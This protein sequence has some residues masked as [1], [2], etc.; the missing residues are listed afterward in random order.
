[1]FLEWAHFIDANFRYANEVD[2]DFVRKSIR[3]IGRCAIKIADASDKCVQVLLELIKGG[4][5]YVVQESIVVVKDI[6][7]KYPQKYE[8][9]IPALCENLE[10]LDNADAKAALVWIIGEYSAKIDNAADLL[11][12]FFESFEDDHSKVRLYSRDLLYA[13]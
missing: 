10:A 7:R 2:V 3:A 1:L 12:F 6:F 4:V 8:A 13:L 11:K 5:N 9:I